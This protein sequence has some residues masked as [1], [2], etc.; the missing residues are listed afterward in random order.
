MTLAGRSVTDLWPFYLTGVTDA[1]PEESQ[2]S[3]CT[4]PGGKR[5]VPVPPKERTSTPRQHTVARKAQ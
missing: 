4:R 5:R 2:V 3:E 1:N